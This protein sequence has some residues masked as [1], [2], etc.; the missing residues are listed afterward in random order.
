MF[1]L[2]TIKKNLS[3]I[4]ITKILKDYC[5][6]QKGEDYL[7]NLI[8]Q[9]KTN[10]VYI[11]IGAHDGLRFSNSFAFSKLGW[12]GICIEAHPDYYNICNELRNNEITKIYNIACSNN[13]DNEI[14]FYTNY[15][16]SLSTLNPNLNEYYKK[17][18]KNYYVDKD[19]NNK[20]NNFTN[21]PIKIQ[22]KTMNTLIEEN[23][24]FLNCNEIDLVSID[25]DGSEEFVL[26]GFDILKYQPRV[27]I[28]EVSVVR[29]VVEK[30]MSNTSYYK[31]HDNGINVIYCRDNVDKQL[32]NN[33]LNKL[34]NK[35]IISYDTGHPL[36]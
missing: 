35:T 34:N 28:L 12:R 21:G 4:D 31:I 16:G 27:I 19:S 30:Y 22:A 9:N 20:V 8:F 17:N 33:E 25:V 3:D 24:E 26:P 18:F 15:R 5:V 10:G 1:N 23:K 13:D 7:V 2:K 14:T 32:F 11:D 29:S 6:S 36:D